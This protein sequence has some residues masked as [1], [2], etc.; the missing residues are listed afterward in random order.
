MRV[1]SKEL[2]T[3][4][5]VVLANVVQKAMY[6]LKIESQSSTLLHLARWVANQ[7]AGHWVEALCTYHSQEINPNSLCVSASLFGEVSR[8]PKPLVNVKLDLMTLAYNPKGKI[9]RIRPQPDVADF[10]KISDVKGLALREQEQLCF[11]L[12]L[13]ALFW[14]GRGCPSLGVGARNAFPPLDFDRS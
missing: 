4:S 5:V 7:G 10:L 1:C 9:E 8:L 2:E 13:G 6:E 12:G 3:S 11:G 14:L